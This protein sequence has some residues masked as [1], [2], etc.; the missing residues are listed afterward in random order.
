[1][2]KKTKVVEEPPPEPVVE[3]EPEPDYFEGFFC[4]P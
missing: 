3:K 2:S 1:M 4:R